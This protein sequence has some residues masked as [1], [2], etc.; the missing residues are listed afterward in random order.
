MHRNCKSNL[1]IFVEQDFDPESGFSIPI[2]SFWRSHP[3]SRDK[4]EGLE[5]TNNRRDNNQQTFWLLLYLK[6]SLRRHNW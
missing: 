5:Y 4:S 2:V 1:C 3:N 6:Q